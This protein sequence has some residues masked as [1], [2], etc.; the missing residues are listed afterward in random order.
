MLTLPWLVNGKEL[1]EEERKAMREIKLP[2]GFV[3]L[4]SDDKFE[5]LNQYRWGVQKIGQTWY[6]TR[7]EIFEHVRN[8]RKKIHYMHRDAVNAEDDEEVDH[9]DGNGLNNQDDNLRI[10]TH[11]QNIQNWHSKKYSIYPGITWDKAVRKWIARIRIGG[12]RKYLGLFKEEKDAFYAYVNA[13]EAIG[14]ALLNQDG[15]KDEREN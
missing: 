13:L 15:G 9:I 2:K 7:N 8:G 5:M 1:H 4:V 12:K 14:E 11:R 3:A 6:A 10:V